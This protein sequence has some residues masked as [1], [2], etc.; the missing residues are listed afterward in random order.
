MCGCVVWSV[1]IILPLVCVVVGVCLSLCLSGSLSVILCV[2][3]FG[4]VRKCGRVFRSGW[5]CRG[6]RG[7][8]LRALVGVIGVV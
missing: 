8:G 1:C 2:C 3:V 5:E 6:G 7:M 4:C